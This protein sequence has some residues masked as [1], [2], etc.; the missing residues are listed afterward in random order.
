MELVGAHKKALYGSTNFGTEK[1]GL[2]NEDVTNS[3]EE[4]GNARRRYAIASNQ[5]GM[6]YLKLKHNLFKKK[7]ERERVNF[8]VY[9]KYLTIASE[10]AFVPIILVIWF[11]FNYF[12]FK[13]FLDGSIYSQI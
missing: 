9:W 6:N 5:D 8:H 13:Q 10:G 3:D 2:D 7:R 1:G 4:N 11:C 12:R